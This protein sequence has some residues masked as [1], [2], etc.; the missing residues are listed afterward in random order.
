MIRR[1]CNSYDFPSLASALATAIVA[2]LVVASIAPSM[3]SAQED[4]KP[5]EGF[6]ALFDG[7]SLDGW[8]G[9]RKNPNELWKLDEQ[10]QA[11]LRAD[12]L[13]DLKT[14]WTVENGE[15]VNDGHGGYL[16]TEKE[17]GDYELWIDYKTVAKADSGI[18][19]RAT[20]Q[21]QI[22]DYTDKGKFGIGADKGSGGLW[23]NSKGSQGQRSGRVGR[24][25]VWR[26]EPFSNS[27]NRRPHQ[28]MAQRQTRCRSCHHG[29]FLG[30][31]SSTLPPR[32]NPAP[33]SRWRDSLAQCLHS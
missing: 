9:F 6:T 3:A 20:P 22:W 29:E 14:H 24:Q 26:V 1:S 28:R 15:I 33:N 27:A 12:S 16:T 18:Y 10:Q 4:N 32:A 19:L 8:Y 31:Q 25:G 17:Y 7:K 30:S 23:N 21:V 11:K 13:A 5:P 2:V